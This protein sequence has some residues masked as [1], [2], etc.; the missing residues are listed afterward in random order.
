VELRELGQIPGV[1]IEVSAEDF[2]FDAGSLA[3]IEKSNQTKLVVKTLTNW[4]L[5]EPA[6]DAN[7]RRIHFHFLQNPVE[8]LGSDHVTGVRTERTELIGDGSVRGTGQF[9]D[10]PVGAVYRAI[11]YFGSPLPEVPFDPV[12]GV[13]PNRGGRVV[14]TP[15]D[16]AAVVPRL[17]TTGWIKRGPVGL[18]GSTKSD[19]AETVA[20]LLAD[21]G[22]QRPAP[23]RDADVI[24]Q[25]LKDRQVEFLDWDDFLRLDAYE[26]ALG[27][28]E[29][30]ERIKVVPR[31]EMIAISKGEVSPS[32]GAGV[33]ESLIHW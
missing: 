6:A 8:I 18:I 7:A 31:Q 24:V 26:M 10:W 33:G 23:N 27:K 12:H 28:S 30:R 11:G 13:I 17:Y 25:L 32:S 21:F 14:T 16:E 20:N 2:E 4:T 22:S 1:E 19:A 15:D 29:G 9:T 5:N 3:A